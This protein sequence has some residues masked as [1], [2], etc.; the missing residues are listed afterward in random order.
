MVFRPYSL[1]AEDF[2]PVWR[3]DDHQLKIELTED[4]S[5]V[6]VDVI[7]GE[8]SSFGRLEAYNF[9]GQM[10]D[11]VTSRELKS[12]ELARL[13][14]A[15]DRPEIAYVIV[16]GASNTAIKIDNFR[17]GPRTSTK[18]DAFGRYYFTSLPTGDYRVKLTPPS[19]DFQLTSPVSGIQQASVVAGQVTK[20]VNFGGR[21][22]GSAW[23]NYNLSAD[24]ND[25]GSVT[26]LDALMIINLL[27]SRG[28]GALDNTLP[29]YPF[30]DV[31]NS[32]SLEP[33]DVL[34]V[35]NYLNNRGGGEGEFSGG[36]VPSS[37]SS[38]TGTG[39]SDR[40]GN[41][42]GADI[43]STMAD[44]HSRS[45]SVADA[46]V[47]ATR[48]F[49]ASNSSDLIA[50]ASPNLPNSDK[51]SSRDS[52]ATDVQFANRHPIAQQIVRNHLEANIRSV[53]SLSRNAVE[54]RSIATTK[55]STPDIQTSELAGLDSVFA[56]DDFFRTV[57]RV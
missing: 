10:L 38:G 27:N 22:Q 21:F 57:L 23:H 17:Y 16:K 37:G 50:F 14:L 54:N 31:S 40:G 8:A 2:L 12:G 45:T 15:M 25:S 39:G 41:G 53:G 28:T 7:G 49:L 20:G 44:V 30:V 9:D 46:G 1:L 34:L 19:S 43:S 26:P 33:L 6:S 24:V 32:E 18:T 13:E 56:D 29:N 11:R 51:P 35:I 5:F 4:S 52:T 55:L 42:E 47:N 3:G 48:E 36:D